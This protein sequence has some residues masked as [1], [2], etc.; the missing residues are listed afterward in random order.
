MTGNQMAT[1][2]G[3]PLGHC[4]GMVA[5]L[6]V[7]LA[8]SACG[9]GGGGA[10]A[11]A[12]ASNVPATGAQVSSSELAQDTGARRLLA[13][14]T[15][16]ANAEA[17]SLVKTMGDEA[18]IDQQLDMPMMSTTH[19]SLVE[20]A[21]AALNNDKPRA[22]ELVASW[23]THAV[24]DPAQVRERWTYALSQ[25][26]VVSTVDAGLGDNSR[27]VASYLDM[28]N[29]KG[30][31][32]Y[33]ALIEAVALHPA[34]GHYLSHL[35]NRKEDPVSGR[36]PDENFARELM[37]L[38]SIGLYEL[39]DDG[40]LK[41]SHGQPVET[42]GPADIQG[43][44]KVFTGWSYYN[45][46]ST[47]APWWSC[48]WSAPGCKYASQEV[49]PM[50]AYP[51]AHATSEKRFLGVT[52][53]AQSTADPQASLKAALDRLATHPNTAPFISRQLIQ[54]LVT[55]NPSPAYVAR[56]SAVFR[57][58]GGQLKAVAK[59]ILL[60]PEARSPSTQ[61]I[62]MSTYGKLREPVLRLAQLLRAM[63]HRSSTYARRSGVP[64]YQATNTDDPSNA[65]GQTPMNSPS[66]FNFFRPG[67]RPAQSELSTRQMVSPE[68]QITSETSVIGYARFMAGILERG[69]GAT[70]AGEQQA[71]IQFDLSSLVALDTGSAQAGAAALV[72]E[73]SQ[74]LLGHALPEAIQTKAV[75]TVASLP[76]T[77]ATALRR[78]AITALLL[79]LVSP[80]YTVQQ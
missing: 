63:P 49:M 78:R 60:D 24:Q 14:S 45:P 2:L 37:Q 10:S 57:S 23:W 20:A 46:P 58:S 42:Y 47:S 64:F 39:N 71:D 22:P 80:D 32:T 33:R 34:M 61:G 51:E 59:A 30:L 65:L 1:R 54:H 43:L 31:G 62:D 4:T 11:D 9:G 73:A 36:V 66:V 17:L 21:S 56:I 27:L 75:D 25:I 53:P 19:L 70:P 18:W 52:V 41:L 29:D 12:G 38:F 67:Y 40:S 13:Q 7:S 3:Q 48:F 6:A 8:L 44:A 76:R 5:G 50:S 55:S 69:W 15:F 35:A 16:G 26:F 72:A 79:V 77:N 74:R 68:M 28:L